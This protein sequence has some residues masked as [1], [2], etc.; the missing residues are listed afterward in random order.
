MTRVLS[1]FHNN[2]GS[3]LSEHRTATST[4]TRTT[5]K[6]GKKEQRMMK[7]YA[8]ENKHLMDEVL[9]LEAD[10]ILLKQK[11]KIEAVEAL[12]KKQALED[13]L[14]KVKT[15]NCKIQ[16]TLRKERSSRDFCRG[17]LSTL[18]EQAT[19]DRLWLDQQTAN[20]RTES[21]ALKSSSDA[22]I[23]KAR[24]RMTSRW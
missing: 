4:T 12:V 22:R 18:M 23:E 11:A 17:K 8:I 10:I 21:Q 3:S 1:I 24:R 6:H 16:D 7:K 13:E 14:Q 19:E 20:R 2:D 9:S 5:S 15:E